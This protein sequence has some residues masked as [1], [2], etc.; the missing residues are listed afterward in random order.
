MKI[1][2]LDSLQK[3]YEVESHHVPRIG[4]RID[5]G[6]S[7]APQVNDVVWWPKQKEI[8]G[9]GIEVLLVVK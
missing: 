9:K 6:Y 4:D 2:I 3:S 8:I 5:L 1:A 7:P